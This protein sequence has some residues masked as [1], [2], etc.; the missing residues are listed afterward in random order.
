MLGQPDQQILDCVIVG[1]GL[2]GLSLAHRFNQLMAA[3]PTK[4]PPQ[5]LL[6]L[7]A[8]DRVGGNI[9]TNQADGFVW[10]EGPTSFSPTLGLLKLIVDLN[11]QSEL[12][13]AD[14]RLPR[15][16][17]WQG[18]L[19]PLEPTS[20][21]GLAG[22]QLLSPWGKVR[23]G[24]GA[25]GFVQ[26][27]IGAQASEE[28]VNQFF[29]RHLGTEVAQR[30]VSPFVS[31]V[32]AGDVD[33]LSASAAFGKLTH[34][35]DVGG[36]LV[37]GAILSR[38]GKPKPKPDPSLP[39][40]K[41]GELG[42]FKRGLKTLPEAIAAS[43]PICDQLR[44]NWQVKSIEI[45]TQ[46]TYQLAIATPDGYQQLETRSLVLTC[47]AYVSAE[48]L[49]SLQPQVSQALREFT[50]PTV[51]CVILAYPDSALPQPLNGF[52]N[53]IPRQQ[54]I[55][56]LGTI[57]SSSLFPG[58]TPAGWHVL[59]NFIGGATDPE[60]AQLTPDEIVQIV[61][62]NLQ[63]TLGVRD[64]APKVLGVHIWPRAIPQYTLG[65]FQRLEQIQTGL[66]SLPGVFLCS[67]Y[68]GGVALGDRVQRG[69]EQALQLQQY[70]QQADSTHPQ[71]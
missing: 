42:S 53:L 71:A 4:Q 21:L 8:S 48:I 38:R 34:L 46:K 2:S 1:A 6:V 9:T 30:L 49:Q 23:A 16:V 67:N 59:T 3:E 65:H 61:H 43:Q 47:P 18:H 15:F 63:Q 7:E 39:K 55:R 12:V 50:Y 32:F 19:H 44:L 14:G 51:A 27:A 41:P 17:Y 11:L 37:A 45:T 36:S 52:G 28:T 35:A 70:L 40:T 10:E 69:Q 29:S 54:G 62:G 68:F 20:P 33:Q 13:L 66:Q 64:I 26:P 31:G 56:T 60:I 5:Q 22:T 24:L 25:L 57:W 58:R